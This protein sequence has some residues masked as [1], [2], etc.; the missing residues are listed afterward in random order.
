MDEVLRCNGRMLELLGRGRDIFTDVCIAP[1]GPTDAQNYRKPSPKF[2]VEMIGKYGFRRCDCF[3][4]GDK[5]SDA[6]AAMNA[7]INPILICGAGG[8]KNFENVR[9]F[10]S[11][12]EFS[13]WLMSINSGDGEMK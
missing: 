2:I 11:I 12:L 3:M 5:E 6:L 1:E 13:R 7:G 9:T 10:P 8:V 4:V